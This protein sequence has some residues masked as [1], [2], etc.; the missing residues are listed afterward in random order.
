MSRNACLSR[1]S[2]IGLCFGAEK[3][4]LDVSDPVY[5]VSCD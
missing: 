4:T 3:V 1:S 2:D 5:G